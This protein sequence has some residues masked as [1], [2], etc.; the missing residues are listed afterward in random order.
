MNQ[1]AI[2]AMCFMFEVVVAVRQLSLESESC[3][4]L[5]A[6][7]KKKVHAPWLAATVGVE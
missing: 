7:H 6:W 1:P 5:P 2:A 4:S 3:T